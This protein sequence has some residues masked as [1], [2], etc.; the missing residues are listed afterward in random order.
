MSY[1]RSLSDI[2]DD[3]HK[4]A[5]EKDWWEE[6]YALARVPTRSR[7]S[8]ERVASK[9][10]LIVTEVAEAVEFLRNNTHVPYGENLPT[11]TGTN[12]HVPEGLGVE[13][14]DIVIRT[15]D[16]AAACGINLENQIRIKMAFNMNRPYK[17]GNKSI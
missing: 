1:P 9:C 7:M 4:W 6:W 5:V 11:T 13:L 3:I 17:H 12:G 2:Q 8:D 15:L 16:L 10:M 14:A